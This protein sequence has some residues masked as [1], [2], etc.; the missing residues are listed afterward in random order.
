ME[1]YIDALEDDI[2][3]DFEENSQYKEAVISETCQRS[4]KLYFQEPPELQDLVST[5][6]LVQMFL[7]K[8]A[9]IDKI[10]KIIQRKV[11]KGKHLPIT[12]KE[13]QEGYLI[14]PYYI[15]FI[16]SKK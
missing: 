6:K 1:S 11:L 2:N 9:D 12:I 7:T 3:M 16:S 8:Q 5:G 4:D 15:I 14:G 13:V 10:L